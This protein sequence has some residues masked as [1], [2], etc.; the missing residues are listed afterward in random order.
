MIYFHRKQIFLLGYNLNP[1]CSPELMQGATYIQVVLGL[2]YGLFISSNAQYTETVRMEFG[3]LITFLPSKFILRRGNKKAAN[4][5]LSH[6]KQQ[7]NNS[8]IRESSIQTIILPQSLLDWQYLGDT[9]FHKLIFSPFAS[10]SLKPPTRISMGN[11]CTQL[12]E[13]DWTLWFASIFCL[14][15]VFWIDSVPLVEPLQY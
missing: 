1:I 12:L 4:S 7:Q 3:W 10:G 11:W 8:Q 15:V 5:A 2:P 13:D 14:V 9:V 6:S